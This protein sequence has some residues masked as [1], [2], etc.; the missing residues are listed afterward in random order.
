MVVFAK[1]FISKIINRITGSIRMKIVVIFVLS[2]TL[3]LALLGAISYVTYFNSMQETVSKHTSEIA[4]QLN[5]NLEL[6]FNNI[7]KLLDIGNDEL[8]LQ[9]LEEKDPQQ[10][11]R[12]AK[13]IGIKFDIYKNIYDFEGI[14]SDVNIIGLGGNSISERKGVYSYSWNL[15]ES[16]AFQHAAQHPQQFNIIIE[17]NKP[18]AY[19]KRQHVSLENTFSV[20]KAIKRPLTEELKGLIVVDIDKAAIEHI[21]SNMKL[22][23]TGKFLVVN[24]D[25]NLIYF[26]VDKQIEEA[27]TAKLL[28]DINGGGE[29]Y[30]I[31][32]INGEKH[33]IVYNTLQI[34]GWKI[35]GIV[36]LNEIMASAYEVQKWTVIIEIGLILAVFLLYLLITNTMIFPIRELR[37][38]MKMVESGNLDVEAKYAHNDELSD[39]SKGFNI[40]I[41][42][43][44]ELMENNAIHQEN[45]KKSEFKALQAQIN[46]HFLYNTLDAIIWTAEADNKQGVVN[47]T[48]YLSTFFRVAL[49]S[50]KEWILIQEEIRHVDSYLSIQKVRY[51]DILSYT[52]DVDP[53]IMDFQIL[54]LTLQPIVENALYHGLKNK[55]GGGTIE[56]IGNKFGNNEILFQV[57]DNGIGMTPNALET[58]IKEIEEEGMEVNPTGAFGL[59]NIN[60]RI[61]LYYGSQCGITV[62]SEYQKGTSVSVIIP[63]INKKG[64][65]VKS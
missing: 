3:P 33:F 47:I 5:R 38:K 25:N 31:K 50:G 42:K 59:K 8:I 60:Q 41:V 12:K 64:K 23:N 61:K 43:I 62:T 9:Y 27:F 7:N 55:R 6:F 45:L 2:T 29:G 13:E 49:S 10:K 26:P 11:Y 53:D 15:K 24:Q 34:P 52:I 17:E 54:K 36:K 16:P 4:N 48:K 65:S 20:T 19:L 40:M 30:F 22:G 39:L 35:I 44:K 14:V 37:E 1:R 56:I 58:L 57:N 32:K 63:M 46:P 21:C 51:R 18:A 28:A